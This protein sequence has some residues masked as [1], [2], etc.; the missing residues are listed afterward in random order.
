MA[1]YHP[2][3]G[4]LFVVETVQQAHLRQV[5]H[6]QRRHVHDLIG[7]RYA[8]E[9][10]GFPREIAGQNHFG[11]VVPAEVAAGR[12]LQRRRTGVFPQPD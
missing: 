4:M 3:Q 8:R 11:R 10:A 1:L 2:P 12:Q 9:T 7:V 5:A 6:P